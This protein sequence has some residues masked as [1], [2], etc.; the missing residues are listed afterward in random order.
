[1]AVDPHAAHGRLPGWSPG[2]RI[3]PSTRLAARRRQHLGGRSAARVKR[4]D[5]APEPQ[6]PSEDVR[7]RTS[8]PWGAGRFNAPASHLIMTM[9]NKNSCP[10]DVV[11]PAHGGRRRREPTPVDRRT[12]SAPKCRV[13]AKA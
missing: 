2:C 5:A 7:L 13:P 10:A 3:R 12:E 4:G 1:V 6:P 8:A 11:L 9:A